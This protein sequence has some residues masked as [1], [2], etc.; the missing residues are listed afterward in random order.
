MSIH[1]YFLSPLAGGNNC[2]KNCYIHT[3]ALSKEE[4]ESDS[5]LGEQ[6]DE[7]HSKKLARVEKK[8][9]CA[10]MTILIEILPKSAFM[11]HSFEVGVEPALGL[12]RQV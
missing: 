6:L 7:H 12:R 1:D 11:A 4:K 9:C 8:V 3:L 5:A 2:S 10:F